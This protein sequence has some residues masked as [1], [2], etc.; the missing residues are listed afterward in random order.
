MFP[1]RLGLAL[2][3][4][5]AVAAFAL[6]LLAADDIDDYARIMKKHEYGDFWDRID[7]TRKLGSLGSKK[8]VEILALYLEDPDPAIV[9]AVVVA[10]GRTK[11][12]EGIKLLAQS[13]LLTGQSEK[14]RAHA[15]WALELLKSKETVPPLLKALGDAS[16][17]VR[18]AAARALGYIGDKESAK[19]LSEKLSSAAPPVA[20]AAILRALELLRD[21][22]TYD[23]VVGRF[24]DSNAA[25]R[26]AA[27]RAGAVLGKEKATEGLTKGMESRDPMV[28]IA[29][30]EGFPHAEIEAAVAG[31]TKGLDEAEWQVKAAAIAA[32]VR[33]WDKRLIDPLIARME[34]EKGRLRFDIGMA[35]KDLTGKDIGF[36]AR[37]WR[38]WW[39]A[40]KDKFVLPPKPKKGEKRQVKNDG[41]TAAFFNI[42]IYSDRVCFVIDYSGSMYNE[43][44]GK[45]PEAGK[46]AAKGPMRKIDIAIEE[47][48]NVLTRFKP[49][50]KFNL[51][52]ISTESVKQKCR[53]AAPQL[54]QG[55]EGNKK[56]LM[57]FAK[58]TCK[59]LEQIKRGRGDVWDALADAL[60]DAEVDTVFVLSDG[61]PTS[62]RF[63]DD[64]NFLRQLRLD[65]EYRRVMVH[66]VL[67]GTKGT[68]VSFMENI[69]ET[70]GGVAVTR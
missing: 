1:R 44:T 15:A 20:N 23:A 31:V 10:L 8:A 56:A 4:L 13:V 25:V 51:I 40:Q 28:R 64:G 22:S 59:K 70:T 30:L 5:C 12:P 27:L 21:E 66:T 26:A 45:A 14:V 57:E 2:L 34:K 38:G 7:T 47:L 35:L 36:D 32:A 6:P 3:P 24:G 41:T 65:N 18:A 62:G 54:L 11:D 50:V 52:V 19:P 53:K 17:E 49:E 68:D 46:T 16:G 69:A 43:D 58:D 42:P 37:S 61:V 48:G 9:E 39:D 33:V 60:D 55:T 67:T 63:C 29:A